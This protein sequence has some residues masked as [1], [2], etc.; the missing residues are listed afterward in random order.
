MYYTRA[1]AQAHALGLLLAG[2]SPEEV[3]QDLEGRL[4]EPEAATALTDPTNVLLEEV[5]DDDKRTG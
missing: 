4:A 5:R 1:E 2:L 3:E